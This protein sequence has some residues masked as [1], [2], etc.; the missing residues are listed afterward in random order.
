[1][2]FVKRLEL[3]EGPYLAEDPT[4][5]SPDPELEPGERYVLVAVSQSEP[6]DKGWK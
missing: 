5:N 1:M 4:Q 2:A 3:S 6:S